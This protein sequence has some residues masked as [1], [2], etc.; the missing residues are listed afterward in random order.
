MHVAISIE[1][2]AVFTT[3]RDL[4]KLDVFLGLG[5]LGLVF[6]VIVAIIFVLLLFC[7]DFDF[8]RF[9]AFVI[10]IVYLALSKSTRLPEAPRV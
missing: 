4:G 3:A 7:L 1:G 2:Q 8:F 10:L 6:F 5:I 9:L